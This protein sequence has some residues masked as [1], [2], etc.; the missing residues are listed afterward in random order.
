MTALANLLLS[1][2]RM[3][4]QGARAARGLG[5]GADV[6]LG[7]AQARIGG[8]AGLVVR[9]VAGLRAAKRSETELPIVPGFYEGLADEA[10][11]F[12]IVEGPGG[13]EAAAP[14]PGSDVPA[15]PGLE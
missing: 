8:E 11:A 6:H 9:V 1:L 15:G 10:E 5:L 4:E 12:L 2:R 3:A 7:R 14:S 13:S